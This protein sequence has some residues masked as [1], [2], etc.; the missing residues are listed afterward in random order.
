MGTNIPTRSKIS[1]I[2]ILVGTFCLHE[3]M[4][5]GTHTHTHTHTHTQTAVS[6]TLAAVSTACSL[7]EVPRAHFSFLKERTP[8]ALEIAYINCKMS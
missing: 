8:R 1:G 2:A 5:Y 3:T 7:Q 4:T 6:F